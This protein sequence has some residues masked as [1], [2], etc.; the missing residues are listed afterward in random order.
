[1]FID[2]LLSS[3]LMFFSVYLSSDTQQVNSLGDTVGYL[4]LI[5]SV[6]EI[7]KLS[8]LVVFKSVLIKQII[9]NEEAFIPS[10]STNFG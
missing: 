2:G 10:Y 9:M 6:S 8:T 3:P 1:M 7:L 4:W 5:K